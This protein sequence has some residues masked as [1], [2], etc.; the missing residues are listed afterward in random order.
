MNHL[1]DILKLS[2]SERILMIEKIWDS[3]NPDEIE[4]NTYQT[5]ELDKRLNRLE[6]GKTEFHTWESVKKDLRK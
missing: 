5:Q 2:T 1:Q 3:I 6:E 4:L